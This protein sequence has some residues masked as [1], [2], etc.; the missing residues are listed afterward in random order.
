MQIQNFKQ[1]LSAARKRGPKRVA[2]AVSQDEAALAALIEAQ[3]L[4]IAEARLF[5]DRAKTQSLL[6][7]LHAR[8]DDFL[9]LRHLAH[10]T[11][12]AEEAVL[13]IRMKEADILLKGKVHTSTFL[14]WVLHREQGLRTEQRLLSDVF[15]FENPSRRV[16]SN[17]LVMIT[18]GG[19]TPAP[20]LEQKV[21]ILQNAVAVA[22]RLGN[23]NP[24]V[25]VLS[26]VETVTPA[27]PS[28]IDAALIA[29]MNERGQI[30][31]CVVDGPLALDNAVSA[32]AAKTKGLAS[33]VAG[34]ADILVCPNIESA[35]LLAKSTTYFAGFRLAHVIMGATAPV[36]IPSRSDTADAK[37]LSIALGV[38]TCEN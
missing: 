12:A 6:K 33:G 15:I 35:N 22:H 18:D 9:Q 31:G 34:N 21:E 11:L 13:A 17:Q 28:T 1:L 26:A 19:I 4:G 8:P 38:L 30:T 24:R 3:K 27:L 25:A 20:T 16:G 14:R 10:E 23:K 36:L 37:L 32:Q 5:G 29:K 2:L 7:K